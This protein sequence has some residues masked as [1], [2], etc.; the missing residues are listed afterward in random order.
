M[1]TLT[2]TGTVTLPRVNLLPPEIEE[3]RRFKRVQGGLAAGV[4]VSLGIVAVL[5]LAAN[6]QVS[7]AQDDLAAGKVQETQ[8]QSKLAEFSEV[9]LINSQ[10]EAA[11]AQLEQAMG[12]EVR[13]S[14][15]LNDMSL[16]I[17]NHVWLT[18]MTVTQQVDAPATAP[19]AGSYAQTGLGNIAFEGN[20]YTHKDVAAWLESLGKEKGYAQP[21]FTDSTLVAVGSQDV[22]KFTSK[23]ILTADALSKRY[24]AKAGN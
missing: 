11:R 23:V 10:V 3:L 1:S 15:F 22:V 14:Y 13:W 21:Y 2:D 24:V 12:Q 20:G 7:K 5:F 4:V 17:P 19:V 6:A 8:L 16:K 18:K 9:P